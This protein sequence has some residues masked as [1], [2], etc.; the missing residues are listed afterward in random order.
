MPFIYKYYLFG[1]KHFSTKC[2]FLPTFAYLLSKVIVSFITNKTLI[3]CLERSIIAFIL[4]KRVHESPLAQSKNSMDNW[5]GSKMK[6]RMNS[7]I[8]V[9]PLNICRIF[10]GLLLATTTMDTVNWKR[11]INLFCLELWRKGEK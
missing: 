1:I 2:L 4:F 6:I 8:E 5:C 3:E 11:E 7:H 10:V 9:F